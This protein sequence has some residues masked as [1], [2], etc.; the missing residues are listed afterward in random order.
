M[1][2]A[3]ENKMPRPFVIAPPGLNLMWVVVRATAGMS[4]RPSWDVVKGTIT[5]EV[6]S[7]PPSNQA[8]FEGMD[9]RCIA[10]FSQLSVLAEIS[11]KT[12]VQVGCDVLR[13]NLAQPNG[14]KKVVWG[15]FKGFEIVLPGQY[16]QEF[17]GPSSF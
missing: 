4:I 15:Q 6:V 2:R 7:P 10:A 12:K 3:I 1:E 13:L 14:L 9:A 16:P 11:Y 5:M 8:D 17:S